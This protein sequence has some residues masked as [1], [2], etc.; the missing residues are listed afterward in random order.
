MTKHDI[1]VDRQTYDEKKRE[2]KRR[3]SDDSSTT[4]GTLVR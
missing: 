4:E 3:R 2:C 1:K